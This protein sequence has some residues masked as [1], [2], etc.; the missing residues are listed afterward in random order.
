MASVSLTDHLHN[1]GSAARNNLQS[2]GFLALE[3][4]VKRALCDTGLLDDIRD[5]RIMVSEFGEQLQSDSEQFAS[6]FFTFFGICFF[7]RNGI[8]PPSNSKLIDQSVDLFYI[9]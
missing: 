8:S 3:M 2:N 6:A 9:L 1:L 4:P 5:F 7:A